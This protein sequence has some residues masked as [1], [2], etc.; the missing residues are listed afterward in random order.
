[1]IG[2]MV[3]QFFFFVISRTREANLK[4]VFQALDIQMK[5]IQ[6]TWRPS[7]LIV[8]NAQAEINTL[9]LLSYFPIIVH[10]CHILSLNLFANYIC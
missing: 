5:K 1:M 8:D 7:S 4:P 2:G 9:R 6:G 3:S 10:Q